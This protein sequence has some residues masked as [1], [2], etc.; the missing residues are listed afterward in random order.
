MRRQADEDQ[1]PTRGHFLVWLVDAPP[2]SDAFDR[3]VAEY[4]DQYYRDIAAFT[5]IIVTTD[6]SLN[7][8]D[9]AA[10][11]AGIHSRICRSYQFLLRP[12]TTPTK[13][14]VVFVGNQRSYDLLGVV[15]K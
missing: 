3:A 4:D 6:L 15:Q 12:A 9:S 7:V 8:P 11:S 1:G 5:D 2:N 14:A 13:N 10:N